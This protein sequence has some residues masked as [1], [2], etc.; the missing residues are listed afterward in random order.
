MSCPFNKDSLDKLETF[1]DICKS[2]PNI[3]H[4]P[5]L[6]FFKDY[7]ESVGGVLPPVTPEMHSPTKES[8]EPK[9]EPEEEVVEEIESEESDVE[10]DMDGCIEPDTVDDSDK[11]GE[12]SK[13]PTDEDSD[14]ADEKRRAAMIEFGEGNY[15]KAVEL[16]SE[17][18]ELNPTSAVLFVKRGQS[19]LKLNRPNACIKDCTRA[20]ELNPDSAAGY[21]FRGRAHRLIGNFEDAA[22]DLQQACKIDFDEQ[23]DE[24]LKEVTPNAQK[25]IQHKMKVE[26]KKAEK[27][28]RER[29][30]RVRKAKEAHAKAAAQEEADFGDTPGMSDFYKA[31]Q[32]P[33]IMAA[34]QDPE[35]ATA[36]QDISMNPANFMKYQSN[37]KIMALIRKLQQKKFPGG[38]PGMGGFPGAGFGGGPDAPAP[39]RS[40]PM[41]DDGLD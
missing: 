35:V 7:I 30:E 25:I 11:M 26:R 3:L 1:I 21:K 33:E 16:L 13:I 2:K 8:T 18:I 17:A 20:L 31:F 19:Y 10:L 36:M 9:V 12:S 29:A 40:G 34:F 27:D 28:L 38:F 41:E 15:S 24:W 39:P 5:E 23:A 14:N 37:P 6:K 4:L 32:D 22:K